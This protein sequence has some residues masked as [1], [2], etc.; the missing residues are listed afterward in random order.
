MEKEDTP[1]SRSELFMNLIERAKKEFRPISYRE[2]VDE[3][4]WSAE[5]FLYYR[6]LCKM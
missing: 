1:M 2:C 6:E 4:Q 3:L 5:E